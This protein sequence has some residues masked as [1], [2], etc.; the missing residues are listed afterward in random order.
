MVQ[1]LVWVA[2][3]DPQWAAMAVPPWVFRI[4]VV[5]SALCRE[6][7]MAIPLSCCSDSLIL[8]HSI[9]LALRC[10]WSRRDLPVD[11]PG[12]VPSTRDDYVFAASNSL[13][14]DCRRMGCRCGLSPGSSRV[15]NCM[16]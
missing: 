10:A 9:L 2:V 11:P 15:Q 8:I 3:L 13:P 12:A 7:C 6:E 16:W 1:R 14:Y 4:V 5:A